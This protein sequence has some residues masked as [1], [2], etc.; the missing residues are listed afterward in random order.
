M[1][2]KV[3]MIG[4]LLVGGVTRSEAAWIG[5]LDLNSSVQP[6]VLRE[7]HDGQWLTGLSH[8]NL[9]HL[10]KD[11]TSVFHLGLYQVW[12]AEH[13]NAS[14][15]PLVGVDLTG[16][17]KI[18]GFDVP[19]Q[20]GNLGEALHIPDLFK[21]AALISSMLSLDVVVGARPVHTA[22]VIGELIY[23]VGF[24]LSV[25]LSVAQQAPK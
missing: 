21:P 24:T 6:I 8:P 20:I 3:L 12:N 7:L 10:D 9:W 22:D 5:K 23:G 11:G 14:F 19:V 1:M 15:G 16:L 17:S 18:A 4:M 25:P 2:K 13:G